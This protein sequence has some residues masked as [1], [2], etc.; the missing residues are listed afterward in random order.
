M[1]ILSLS[2]LICKSTKN[3]RNIDAFLTIIWF[4]VLTIVNCN[5]QS[6][7]I[8]SLFFTSLKVLVILLAIIIMFLLSWLLIHPATGGRWN[9]TV[10]VLNW[11]TIN[12]LSWNVSC[13]TADKEHIIENYSNPEKRFSNDSQP[14]SGWLIFIQKA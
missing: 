1:Y 10:M 4:I 8:L 5:L 6:F 14:F 3:T 9:V 11:K 7:S 2:S 13:R 12:L